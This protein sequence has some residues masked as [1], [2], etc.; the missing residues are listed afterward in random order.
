MYKAVSE[1]G[2]TMAHEVKDKAGKAANLD[3]KIDSGSYRIFTRAGYPGG[4]AEVA[5]MLSERAKLSAD[6]QMRSAKDR[7]TKK[8]G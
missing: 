2:P 3:R 8:T 1:K 7:A 6:S 5:R 4:T